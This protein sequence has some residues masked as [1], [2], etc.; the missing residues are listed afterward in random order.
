MHLAVGPKRDL[1]YAAASAEG[2][3]PGSRVRRGRVRAYHIEKTS[4]SLTY[5][6][7]QPTDGSTTC[8][9]AVSAD[10][11]SVLAAN[12]RQ[13][14]SINGPGGQSRGSVAVLPVQPDG[15]L[16]EARD[17]RRHE[18]SSL[19]PVRQT[20][21][22]PHCV[23]VHPDGRHVFVTDL[24][25]DRVFVYRLDPQTHH[26]EPTASGSVACAPPS[27]PRHLAIH[28][29]G[30]HVY[31]I[32]EIASTFIGLSFDQ[33]TGAINTI[34]T[35]ST[36]PPG[37]DKPNACADVHVHT[38]GRF[39]YGSNRGHRSLVRYAV[40]PETGMMDGCSITETPDCVP[41]GF[42]LTQQ[43][44][45]LLLPG[46]SG[47]LV[48]PIDTNDGSLSQVETSIDMPCMGTI[49]LI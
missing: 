13:Y 18:G 39:L 43:G 34:Q 15:S 12:F 41:S 38:S 31:V 9:V 22:H 21:S 28:P 37:Y 44:D 49:C 7:E 32:T 45:F 25:V 20:A 30:R 11:A 29:N 6:N 4:L 17:I 14:G 8:Y 46:S 23:R 19:H 36:V 10:G 47:L 48:F 3:D 16:G 40:D 5:L 33:Q 26:I 35:V 24:G 1:L 2:V 42:E 27:G